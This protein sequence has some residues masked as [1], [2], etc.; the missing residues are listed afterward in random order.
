M[1]STH[2][3]FKLQPPKRSMR[4][5]NMHINVFIENIFKKQTKQ[6]DITL[7]ITAISKILAHLR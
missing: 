7:L 4:K 2:S 6:T 1:V 5:Q 3:K